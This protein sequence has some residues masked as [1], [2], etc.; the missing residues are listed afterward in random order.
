MAPPPLSG[1]GVPTAVSDAPPS[2]APTTTPALGLKP[3]PLKPMQP[4]VQSA[5][6]PPLSGGGGHPPQAPL[7]P[8]PSIPGPVSLATV[9]PD[10]VQVQHDPAARVPSSKYPPETSADD[11]HDKSTPGPGGAK[12]PATW[13]M[14][15]VLDLAEPPLPKE[16]TEQEHI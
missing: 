12:G 6:A 9:H 15:L 14:A 10:A 1:G 13:E 3:E 2:Q 5:I 8:S 4:Q 11:A 16:M 7:Q